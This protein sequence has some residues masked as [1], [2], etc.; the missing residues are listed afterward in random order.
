MGRSL[1]QSVAT[2]QTPAS[3]LPSP[4]PSI[5]L[6]SGTKNHTSPLG[7]S[8]ARR[9]A[10]R[11]DDAVLAAGVAEA[12]REAAVEAVGI[13]GRQG[14]HLVGYRHLETTGEHDAAFLR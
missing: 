2:A 10:R 11:D 14:A 8:E 3:S 5:F 12:M 13:P 7:I 4:A 6:I 9:G 1:L